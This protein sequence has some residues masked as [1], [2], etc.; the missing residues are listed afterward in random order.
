MKKYLLIV[1]VV[2]FP[3]FV[4]AA[5]LG[6]GC[7][8]TT[9][10]ELKALQDRG[11]PA[12]Y[13]TCPSD[14]QTI[15]VGQDFDKW[16]AQ[17]KTV[18]P[19]NKNSCALSCRTR[20]TGAQVCGPTAKR[21]NSI[22][23]HPNNNTA[24][25]PT[26][27]YGFAAHIELLRR[28]C[29]ERGRCTIAS[30]INQWST[31]NHPEYINFVSRYSGVPYNQVFN[32]NDIDLMGR[33][34]LTMSCFESGSLPYDVNEMKQG[35]SMAGGGARVAVP[36]NVGQLLN[37]SMQGS[38]SSNPSYSPNSQPGSWSYPASTINGSNNYVPPPP[39]AGT[40]Y[41]PISSSN[42][43]AYNYPMI[44]PS[45]QDPLSNY[46]GSV[47]FPNNSTTSTTTST[48]TSTQGNG[49]NVLQSLWNAITGNN[50]QNASTS[51]STTTET[52]VSISLTSQQ[53]MTDLT[54]G[55][56]SG[57]YAG[58][59]VP[60]VSEQNT[61]GGTS[62]DMPGNNTSATNDGGAGGSYG[63]FS[64]VQAILLKVVS[65]LRSIIASLATK[66]FGQ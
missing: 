56:S 3:H 15:G 46:P 23:C 64:G 65:I 16:Y 36:S 5:T 47:Q 53:T 22:G 31:G 2:V 45:S 48:S 17:L 49:Q 44:S 33:I 1:F 66:L 54:S 63:S 59:D 42:T 30:V 58:T 9:P 61:F 14:T 60:R 29:G 28:F 18:S 12:S 38:Y 7:H 39:P 55:S 20:N 50:S 26:A 35:L 24:I 10:A 11:I 19:C 13:Q 32:P 43:G 8:A 41:P 62:A 40:S 57:S 4:L 21:W 34:A 6:A 37:E 25:F 51:Q 27:A 52:N